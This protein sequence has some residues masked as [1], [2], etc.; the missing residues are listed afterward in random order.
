MLLSDF[1]YT[2]PP[3]LIAQSPASP[4]DHSRL[5]LLNRQTGEISHH[6]FYDLPTLL[7]A[8]YTFLANNTK[9]FPARLQGRKPTGGAVEILLLK[10]H[11]HQRYETIVS[12]GLKRGDRILLAPD[13]EATVT[14]VQDR[15]RYLRFSLPEPL[16]TERLSSL[17]TMPTPPYIKRLLANDADYQTI[18]A[19][20]GFSAA[21]PTA[22]LH[23]TPSLLKQ[24]KAQYGWH[25]LTLDVGLGTFLPVKVNDVTTHHMHKERYRLDQHTS[26]FLRSLAHTSQKLVVVGTTTL[27]ALESNPTLSPGE[28]QTEIFIY[29][30]YQFRHTDAL[31]T[32]FHLPGSTLLMLVS[33]FCAAPQTK[34]PFT[35]FAD[36]LLGRA[37]AEAVR[38][39]YRFFSFGDAMLI[40]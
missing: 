1:H 26:T 15:L 16:L 36:S 5:M 39:N 14:H 12:P 31:I 13:L 3:E 4:R 19:K 8:N 24:I 6:H 34:H 22:G 38:L 21:A 37:Y 40:I 23:F 7:P 29:P 30:P 2:L 11:P 9:V 32:N 33:A 27:R 10:K 18:Y 25:E 28:S 35:T 17:G 20:Y